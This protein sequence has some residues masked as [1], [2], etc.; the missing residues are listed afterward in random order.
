MKTSLVGLVI[1][2]V[3]PSISL[4]ADWPQWWGT[5]RDG[6]W[7]E[8]GLVEKFPPRGPTV[9]WRVPLGGG[10]S[11]PAVVGRRV[12]VTDRVRIK[13]EAGNP[14]RNTRDGIP[15]NEA[16]ICL[17][18]SS[19]KEI[20]KHS[21]SC[22][23]QIS[24]ASGPRCTPLI[25]GNRVYT[26]GAMGDLLCLNAESGAVIWSKNI[27][28][29]YHVDPPVW[30][31]AGHPLIDNHR[32]ICTVGGAGSAV[33]AF[34]KETGKEIWKGL[35]SEEVGYSPPMI[36]EAGG[37]RQLIIW[38][39]ETLNSLDP[40]TGKPYWTQ[41]Y[42]LDTRVQ[43]PAVNIV[44]VRRDATHL[45]IST[46]YHGPMMLELAANKPGVKVLWHGKSNNPNK[47]DGLHSLMATAVLKDGCIYGVCAMG[48]LRCIDA[49]TNKQ[50]WQTYQ[51]TGGKRSDC[52]TAFL[53]PQGDRFIIFND[54]GELILAKLSP[55]GYQ[56]ISKAKILDPNEAARGRMVVWS[57]PAFA[58]R[59]VFARNDKEMVCVSLAD[60]EK[61]KTP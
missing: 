43:R 16:V 24:Y 9:V 46:F 20:W 55:A 47:P 40:E 1:L 41:A 30:G 13:D 37:K 49:A 28:K 53:I 19:G 39:S 48:E 2:A 50:L 27:A 51:A 6:V 15:G 31:Y 8:T 60:T 17:D 4:G 61:E 21:Y 32:L 36:F 35:T 18:A 38:L 59:C 58:N 44:T 14:A 11:G 26:L 25:E 45:F 23:Y 29:E 42:P 54:Q 7:H 3:F 12:Y 56:E 34:D 5:Q 10:Y 22:P 52:G 33:V 57:H